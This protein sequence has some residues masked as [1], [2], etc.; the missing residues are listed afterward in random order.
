[1]TDIQLL[2][3]ASSAVTTVIGLFII[4]LLVRIET[5]INDKIEI[6]P[7][8]AARAMNEARWGKRGKND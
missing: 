3:I 7:S 4:F 6:T 1:M 2:L 5:L 8:E